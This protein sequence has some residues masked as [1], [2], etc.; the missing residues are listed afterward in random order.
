MISINNDSDYDN[1]LLF[2][3]YCKRKL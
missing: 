1:M 2:F 3:F